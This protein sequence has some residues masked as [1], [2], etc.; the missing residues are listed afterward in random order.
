MSLN[1]YVLFYHWFWWKRVDFVGF[2]MGCFLVCV[3]YVFRVVVLLFTSCRVHFPAVKGLSAGH[4][5]YRV[6]TYDTYKKETSPKPEV[7]TNRKR[8]HE[9]TDI[10]M[11]NKK[12]KSLNVE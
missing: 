2:F 4:S 1:K 12:R 7:H 8:S 10:D 9:D 11:A 3:V 5:V 6:V